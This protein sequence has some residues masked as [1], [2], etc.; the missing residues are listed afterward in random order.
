MTCIAEGVETADQIELLSKIG[1]S[2]LQ[3]YF[4]ARPMSANR[5]D[6]YIAENSP[7]LSIGFG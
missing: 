7:V 5:V 2:T 4:F 1:C 3:G 6:Q